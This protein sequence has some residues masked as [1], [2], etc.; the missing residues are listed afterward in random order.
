MSSSGVAAYNHKWSPSGKELFYLSPDKKLM[1]ADIETNGSAFDVG[2]VRPLFELKARGFVYFADITS[3]G[4][5]FLIGIEA[6]GQAVPPLT[7]VTN[8]DAALKKK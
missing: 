5:E 7:L 3:D 2:S 1:A 8:W 6:S 4:R